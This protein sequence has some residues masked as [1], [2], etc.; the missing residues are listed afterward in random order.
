[1]D[2]ESSVKTILCFGDSNTW[3][4]NPVRQ[5]RFARNVRWPGVLRSELGPE[6]L[7]I[8]EGLNG[9]TTVWDDP[10]EGFKCGKDYLIPCLDTHAPI[11]LV[12]VLLGTNDLKMRFSVSA[13]D[14]ANSAG[15]LVE[16]VQRSVTGPEG[17]APQVLLLAPPPLARL[18]EFAEMFTGATEKA[19]RFSHHFRRV[20]DEYGCQL[21]DCSQVIISSDIDGIH[22]EAEEHAK[23]G[24]AVANRV[25][26]LLAG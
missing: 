6:Y 19:L 8:E 7:V 23:L 1:M 14:I 20:A 11:D 10:I 18:S 12:I 21:L 24:R 3:G 13:Y 26:A 17:Q 25:K 9:R 4:W 5:D 16:V 15:V 2:W 22:L